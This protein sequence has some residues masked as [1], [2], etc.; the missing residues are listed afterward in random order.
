LIGKVAIQTNNYFHIQ[1]K[2]ILM[3][4]KFNNYAQP[5]VAAQTRKGFLQNALFIGLLLLFSF[6]SFGQTWTGAVSSDWFTA[7]NWDGNEIPNSTTSAIIP[8]TSNSPVISG[9]VATTNHIYMYNNPTLT[10]ASSGTLNI[11]LYGLVNYGTV[12]NSGTLN[13]TSDGSTTDNGLV[14]FGTFNNNAT[15]KISVNN[16]ASG[17]TGIYN[18]EA[19]STFINYG[20]INIGGIS[21]VGYIGIINTNGIFKNNGGAKIWINKVTSTGISNGGIFDNHAEVRIGNLNGSFSYGVYNYSGTFNNKTGGQIYIDRPSYAGIYNSGGAFNNQA[22]IRIGSVAS[23]GNYGIENV[24]TFNNSGI[25]NIVSD[26]STSGNGILNKGTFSNNSG[27]LITIDGVTNNGIEN[28]GLFD[29]QGTLKI[30]TIA[31]IGYYGIHV[32]NGTFK[33]NTGGQIWINRVYISG[34]SNEGTFD[35]QAEIKI[36]NL[37]GISFYGINTKIGSIFNNNTGGQISIDRT[38]DVGI[39]NQGG[40]FNNQALIKIGSIASVGYVGIFND[41]TFNNNIGGQIYI[42]RTSQGG[43]TNIR[44]FNNQAIILI[45]GAANVIN[46]GISNSS[47]FNN[48]SGGLITIDKLTSG[49]GISTNGGTFDNQGTLNIGCVAGTGLTGIQNRGSFKNRNGGLIN[50]DKYRFGITVS[51]TNFTNQSTINFGQEIQN[52]LITNAIGLGLGGFFYNIAGGI[53]TGTGVIESY[54]FVNDAGKL[55]P[56]IMTFWGNE[57]FTNSILDI[58]ITGNGGVPGTDYDKINVSYGSAILGASTLVNLKFSTATVIGDY[59]DIIS[60]NSLIG[61]ISPANINITNIGAGNVGEVSISYPNDNTVRITV[62]KFDCSLTTLPSNLTMSACINQEDYQNW[63]HNHGG[64]VLDCNAG[65]YIWTWEEYDFTTV[66][67]PNTNG[68]SVRFTVSD[69]NG[70]IASATSIV[71]I[72]DED[73]PQWV[74]S[75]TNLTI[76]CN[77][78]NV[79]AT[80]KTWLTNAGGASIFDC[81]GYTLTN[82]YSAAANCGATQVTFTATDKCGRSSS[83]TAVLTRDLPPI[84]SNVPANTT[85]SCPATPSFASPTATACGG[86]ATITYTDAINGSACPAMHTVTRTWV[87]QDACGNTS[88]AKS[89]VTVWP[90]IAPTGTVMTVNCANSFL[91]TAAVGATSAVVNYPVPSGTSTCPLNTVTVTQVAGLASGAVFPLGVSLVT[92]AI[93]DE[94]DHIRYCSF[95]VIVQPSPAQSSSILTLACNNNIVVNAVTVSNNAIVTYALPTATTTCVGNVASVTL[96]SGLASGAAFPLGVNTVVYKATD[97]CGSTATC[98]FTVTLNAAPIP[99]SNGIKLKCSNDVTEV[100]AAGATSAVVNYTAPTG[101][102][103]CPIGGFSIVLYSG[104][105]SGSAFPL[106]VSTVTYRATSNC[107]NE[108]FCSFTVTVSGVQPLQ[109]NNGDLK[110]MNPN[111]EVS[112][113]IQNANAQDRNASIDKNNLSENSFKIYPNPSSNRLFIESKQLDGLIGAKYEVFDNVGRVVITGNIVDNLTDLDISRLPVGH[114]T[115][116]IAQIGKP[117]VLRFEKF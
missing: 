83:A 92:Y 116:R 32:S 7:G 110:T 77:A 111:G 41:F 54:L 98:S 69:A 22:L 60:A 62:T 50:I 34:I 100:A 12:N 81:G 19:T 27:G 103:V 26:G 42:D 3:K 113:D 46:N 53:L 4:N 39:Y 31:T 15:G 47:K 14:N 76:P 91:A 11:T 90:E 16:L 74:T 38:S 52:F 56:G 114:F 105:A 80:I 64:A 63:L 20:E 82:N 58:D 79:D 45:G 35:N 78:T 95:T 61:T 99:A 75:P 43:I 107:G 59:Y 40:A 23:V 67:C 24:A 21:N 44:T 36:G 102:S 68:W 73:T 9:G 49:N 1:T 109:G 48:N 86:A 70:I 30:G 65:D 2:F 33:N 57:N 106:G 88:S 72:V 108:K 13:I 94:C 6:Q 101:T 115:M 89:K 85:I 97:A 84:F 71:S 10:I 5:F 66:N 17:G 87:A 51:S 29:N 25:V 112:D 55:S 93:T 28:E 8:P 18:T 117:V 37:E 104:L 96:V